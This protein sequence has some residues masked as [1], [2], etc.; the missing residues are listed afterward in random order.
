MLNGV[1]NAEMTAICPPSPEGFLTGNQEGASSELV[2]QEPASCSIRNLLSY[3]LE[4]IH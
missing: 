3:S 2:L 1:R 4:I